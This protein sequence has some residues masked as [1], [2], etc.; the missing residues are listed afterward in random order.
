[1]KKAVAGEK[2]RR[3]KN[4]EALRVTMAAIDNDDESEKDSDDDDSDEEKEEKV[5][6]KE[7]S[8]SN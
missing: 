8:G 2:V 3:L 4:L 6:R 5:R 7:Q 1:M